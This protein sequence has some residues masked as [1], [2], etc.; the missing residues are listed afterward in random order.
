MSKTK[1]KSGSRL[2]RRSFLTATA[3]TVAAPAIL[4]HSRAYAQ[5]VVI[6]VGHVSPRTGPLAG[7]AD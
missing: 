4:R 2:S 6:K 7:F 5:D 1:V 3:A